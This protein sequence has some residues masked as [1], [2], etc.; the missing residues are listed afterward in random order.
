MRPVLEEDADW[1]VEA[2][3]A[4]HDEDA[5]AAIGALLADVK[6]L[7]RQ[8]VLASSAMSYGFARGWS[9]ALANELA[10]EGPVRED[11]EAARTT[12]GGG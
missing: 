12:S 6:H 11:K 9:P 10:L 4:W 7:R 3:L 1:E 2:V 8:L 5:K